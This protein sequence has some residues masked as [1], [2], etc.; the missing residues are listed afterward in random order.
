MYLYKTYE[1]K[2]RKELS[3]VAYGSQNKTFGRYYSIKKKKLKNPKPKKNPKTR[4]NSKKLQ[5]SYRYG[6][7]SCFTN[8][9]LVCQVYTTV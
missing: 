2:E 1:S 9:R 7:G 3:L 8:I 6:T 4:K 5:R